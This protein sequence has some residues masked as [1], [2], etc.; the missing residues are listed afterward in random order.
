MDKPEKGFGFYAEPTWMK[1]KGG[2]V[3]LKHGSKRPKGGWTA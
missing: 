2:R 1:A 3:G